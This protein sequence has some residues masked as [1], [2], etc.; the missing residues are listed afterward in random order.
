MYREIARSALIYAVC[1][2]LARGTSILLLPILTRH[3]SPAD[4]GRLELVKVLAA[5]VHVSFALEISQALG[6]HLGRARNA[7][8]RIAY[9]STALGFTGVAYG[10]FLASLSLLSRPL[11]LWIFQT[12]GSSALLALAGAG[13]AAEGLY[14]LLIN[15]LRWSMRPGAY[16]ACEL[17]Y[18]VV[19]SGVTVWL[20]T[21]RSLGMAAVFWG[22]LAGFAAGSL[23]GLI[24]ARGS[25]RPVFDRPKLG[26]MLRFSLPLVAASVIG[27][28]GLQADRLVLKGMG[29]MEELGVYA[30]ACRYGAIAAVFCG[31]FERALA[32]IIVRDADQE[33]LRPRLAT[34]FRGFVLFA[35][36][37]F[38]GFSL[39]APDLSMLFT[40]PEY[41][42]SELLIPL[43]VAA[44]LLQG[45]SMFAPGWFLARRTAAYT[46]VTL[47]VTAVQVVS[48]VL[49]VPRAGALGAAL[50][51]GAGAFVSFALLMAL[52]QKAFPVGHAW[53]R[54]LA[55]TAVTIGLAALHWHGGWGLTGTDSG[56]RWGR[57]AFAVLGI[58]ASALLLLGGPPSRRKNAGPG[59]F[60]GLGR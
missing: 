14:R 1:Q 16:A 54:I 58:G 7:P 17:A 30:A 2:A 20:L 32:P 24:L 40:G 29:T 36:A 51:N 48:L 37:A 3:L 33:A 27:V 26:E 23:L 9:A 25:Y 19:L 12:E 34:L 11:G 52:S 49:L 6:L 10:I 44:A 4:Y 53:G 28:L 57:I 38:L 31:I 13:I 22:Q 5:F 47:A 46:L 55:A 56:G 43:T 18:A 50:A 41:R 39:F 42:S 35:L 15:Q 60:R 45:M 8:E 59:D 21:V